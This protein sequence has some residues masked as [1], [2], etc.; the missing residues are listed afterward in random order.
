[1][2]VGLVVFVKYMPT[3]EEFTGEVVKVR[4]MP[5]AS[6]LFTLKTEINGTVAYRSLYMHKCETCVYLGFVGA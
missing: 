1:M 6:V 3:N 2:K 4:S 5:D